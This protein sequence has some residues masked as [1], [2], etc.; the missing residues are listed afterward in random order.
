MEIKDLLKLNREKMGLTQEQ[1]A[2]K[3]YVSRQAV[4]KWER[5]ESLPDLENI[6][7]L[8]DLYDISIDQI[9]RGAKFLNK[10]FQ[11]G[12]YKNNR[13]LTTGILLSILFASLA[14][15]GKY[16]IAF[17]V[18]LTILLATTVISVMEGNILITK[19]GIKIVEYK[20]FVQK[21]ISIFK[22]NN[23]VTE[24]SFDDISSFKIIYIK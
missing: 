20:N 11:I 1:L 24:Y 8:S 18:V 7:L 13:R 21:L 9:L 14:S 19:Q 23:S 3:I 17:I 4:S 6:I 5:G 22:P 2:E 10:P 16:L 15:G 12:E